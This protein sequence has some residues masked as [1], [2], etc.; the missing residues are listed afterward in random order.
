[1]CQISNFVPANT[2]HW[3]LQITVSHSTH[4]FEQPGKRPDQS[5]P[6]QQP[7]NN[8]GSPD[9]YQADYGQQYPALVKSGQ[10]RVQRLVGAGPGLIQKMYQGAI[11][12]GVRG[13]QF[14]GEFAN[15]L[16]QRQ[17]LAAGLKD[18][19]AQLFRSSVQRRRATE[20]LPQVLQFGLGS[21][22]RHTGQVRGERGV[23]AGCKFRE[24]HP[25]RNVAVL[26]TSLNHYQPVYDFGQVV[27][28]VLCLGGQTGQ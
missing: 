22:G 18:P 12:I 25:S 6:H 17:L 20:L 13:I 11:K 21:C 5:I 23:D 3:G 8:R 24:L 1:M 28:Q 16:F 2:G 10:R 27:S 26:L 4:V 9:T 15:P 7:R 19:L 14:N